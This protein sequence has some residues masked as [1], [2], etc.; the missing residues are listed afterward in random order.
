VLLVIAVDRLTSPLVWEQSSDHLAP[1]FPHR[2]LPSGAV[3]QQLERWEERQ[4]FAALAVV[5]YGF[6]LRQTS[7]YGTI[8]LSVDGRT[9]WFV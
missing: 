5:F 2:G 3:A 7:F 9:A 4:A 1:L 8:V 6:L